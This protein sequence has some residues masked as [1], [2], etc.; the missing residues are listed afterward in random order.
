[1][2]EFAAQN[3]PFLL[4]ILLGK[5][6]VLFL[7]LRSRKRKRARQRRLTQP[8]RKEEITLLDHNFPTWR[9]IPPDLRQKHAGFT[10]VLT[11]EKSYEACGGL[12][13]VT[14]DMRLTI[15]AQAALT[16]IGRDD[17]DFL[18]RLRSI[19]VYPRGFRDPGRRAF[20]VNEEERGLLSGESWET[21]SVVLSWESVLL[22]GRDNDGGMNV[23]IHEFAH[24][25]DQYNGV[26]DG[27]PRLAERNDY[28][29]WVEIMRR[30]YDALV[31]ATRTRDTEPWLDP[32]GATHP[33]EFF[34]VISE[35]FFVDPHGLKHE[36]PDLY[37]ELR[38]FYGLDPVRWEWEDLGK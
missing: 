32:Y 9:K 12:T 34:A 11:E 10:R 16:L 6:V 38:E 17:H 30:E 4:V 18:P 2:N 1:M 7:I 29:R 5:I 19:L 8:F 37:A 28:T 33:A 27:I 26:A 3:W 22:G 31:A 25:L 36:H 14:R 24:Q 23:V 35:A 20:G 21:G 15:A 13:E